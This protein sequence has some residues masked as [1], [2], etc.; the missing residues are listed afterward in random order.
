MF[1]Q[2]VEYVVCLIKSVIEYVLCQVIF[3]HFTRRQS[4]AKLAGAML[5]G[6]LTAL[7]Y[8]NQRTFPVKLTPL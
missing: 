4:L 1:N 5:D 6:R 8:R 2:I 7:T 3:Y